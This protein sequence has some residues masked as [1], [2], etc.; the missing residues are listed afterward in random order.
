[1]ADARRRSPLQLDAELL[2]SASGDTLSIREVAFLTQLDIR[3][4]P[5]IPGVI[6][7]LG[8][9]AGVAM[10][11]IPNSVAGSMSLAA[12]WLGPDEW[13]VVADKSGAGG[14]A[15]LQAAGP[16]DGATIVDVSAARTTMEV[17]GA[18]ARRLL[19][20]ASSIDLHPRSFVTGMCAQTLIGRVNVILWHVT[21]EP[22]FRLFV[23]PSYARHLAMWLVDAKEGLAD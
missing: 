22:R 5:Q 7:E 10:P 17:A 21:D 16:P 6:E 3:G 12:L 15:A 4:D 18:D 2:E 14:L 9:A 11:T 23:R 20:T 1:M 19:E 13:L 8:Y